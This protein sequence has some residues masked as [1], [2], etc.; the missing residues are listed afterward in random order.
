MDETQQN[1]NV[2]EKQCSNHVPTIEVETEP[3]DSNLIYGLTDSP[4]IQVT[5]LCAVQ[6]KIFILTGRCYY[7]CAHCSKNSFALIIHLRA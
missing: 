3:T 4:S 7:I 1:K 6:V 2:D 5:I